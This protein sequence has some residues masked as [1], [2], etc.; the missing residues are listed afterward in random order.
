MA[1]H[2]LFLLVIVTLLIVVGIGAWGYISTRRNQKHGPDVK[3]LGG[4][5]DPMT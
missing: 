4:R 5:N 1:G 3:G 2:P